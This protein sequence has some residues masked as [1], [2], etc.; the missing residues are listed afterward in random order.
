M[1]AVEARKYLPGPKARKDVA[2]RWRN[3]AVSCQRAMDGATA[4]ALTP[5]RQPG[6]QLDTPRVIGRYMFSGLRCYRHD[7]HSN[8]RLQEMPASLRDHDHHACRHLERLRFCCIVSD[9]SQRRGAIQDIHDFV[10]VLMAFPLTFARKAPPEDAA[11][12]VRRHGGERRTFFSVSRVFPPPLQ[13]W[14]CR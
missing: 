3:R 8:R 7:C 2:M 9:E 11:I 13:E 12:T 1:V 10:T 6:K 14:Q 5:G 4:S